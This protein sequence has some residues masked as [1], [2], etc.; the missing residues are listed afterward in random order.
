MFLFSSVAILCGRFFLHAP[1]STSRTGPHAIRKHP[2]TRCGLA[3]GQ[4]WSISISIPLRPE[5]AVLDYL[6]TTNLSQIF[7]HG[8]I[9]LLGSKGVK[10]QW[11][12]LT[13]AKLT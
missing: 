1:R 9:L 6:G 8:E 13:I 2:Q 5:P 11:V 3:F 7:E 4:R 12:N 10:F